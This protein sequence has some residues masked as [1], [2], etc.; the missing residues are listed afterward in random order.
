[1]TFLSPAQPLLPRN[2]LGDAALAGAVVLVAVGVGL[3]AVRYPT[4]A[5][6]AAAL[7]VLFAATARFPAGPGVA[8]LIVLA[9]VPIIT[10]L[11]IDAASEGAAASSDASLLKSVDDFVLIPGFVLLF[12][13]GAAIPRP[14]RLAAVTALTALLA[15][16]LAGFVASDAPMGLQ[17]QAAW[18]DFRWLGAAGWGLV[19]IDWIPRRSR[20]TW[21]FGVL[22][23][24]NVAN[25]IVV[26]L[27][28]GA[29]AATTSRFG[30][31]VV[32]GVFGHPTP[33]AIAATMLIVLVVADWASSPPRL[34]SAQVRS[35]ALV[36]LPALALS[37][38][39]K[40][41][42]ALAA[43]LLLILFV[44]RGRRFIP[45]AIV[46]AS[47][48]VWVTV[49]VVE[50]Q[51]VDTKGAS[52]TSNPVASAVAHAPPRA[53]LVKGAEQIAARQFPFGGGLG[54]YG[55]GL[56]EN[57]EQRS[58]DSVGL[59]AMDGFNASDPRYRADSLV[60]RNLAER[61]VL[62]IVLWLVGSAA[63]IVLALR[64]GG[65]HLFPA[66]ALVS[67][68]ALAP[69]SPALKAT[70][71]TFLFLLP[72]ALTLLALP[73]PRDPKTEGGDRDD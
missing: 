41:L 66:A 17:L 65:G 18:Q 53:L 72:A 9:A 43:T 3:V 48:P 4:A 51:N 32:S 33:G 59:G 25:L 14:Y 37:L 21:A 1:V 63:L 64:L 19:L 69:V 13:R 38:R 22:V 15:S 31:P 28:I 7:L 34:S 70:N 67:A 10:G 45:A 62:G 20:I 58:F 39:F 40:P 26:A 12:A 44:Y 52:P 6:L 61:G 11:T 54:T 23:A 24:W 49:G 46:L 16:E 8:I 5:F 2:R 35:A 29:G 68:L 73:S 55:S 57:V 50:L 42:L 47:L 36:A 71:E 56:D 30:V 27:Q 60:A